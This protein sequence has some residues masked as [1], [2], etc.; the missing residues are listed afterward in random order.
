M[1]LQI[2]VLAEIDSERN[3]ASRS[4]PRLFRIIRNLERTAIFANVDELDGKHASLADDRIHIQKVLKENAL[5]GLALFF[6]LL[7]ASLCE[8]HDAWCHWG[9]VCYFDCGAFTEISRSLGHV[10]F[11]QGSYRHS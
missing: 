8:V 1:D 4:W 6:Q 11:L 3:I 10:E 7:I 2:S 9:F 5:G